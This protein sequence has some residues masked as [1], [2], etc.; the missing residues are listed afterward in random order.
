MPD[1]SNSAPTELPS[2]RKLIRSTIIALVIASVLLVAV[3]LPAEYAVDPTG[4][5]RALGLTQMGEIKIALSK[6]AAADAA[7]A[8]APTASTPAQAP[9][10]AAPATVTSTAQ[11]RTTVRNTH[12][13]LITLEPGQGREIKLVM[14]EG[15]RVK[16]SWATDRGVVNYD[17]HAD[18]VNP[19]RK[20]YGYEKG[21][22]VPSQSGELVAAF[23][24][25][26]GWFWRNR[27]KERLTVTLKTDGEYSELKEIK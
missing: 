1:I 15:A 10:Q 4:I 23:D 12:E 9:A 3:V 14:K 8:A 25:S 7:T 2:T 26:H 5:G 18:S 6:E 24:G 13:T 27:T 22:G 20:Y 11:A 19:P 16:F 17:T 21:A